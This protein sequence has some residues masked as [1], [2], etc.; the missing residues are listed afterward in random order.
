M[1]KGK[2]EYEWDN[3]E[4]EK[5][6][7]EKSKCENKFGCMLNEWPIT[8]KKRDIFAEVRVVEAIMMFRNFKKLLKVSIWK[9]GEPP[10]TFYYDIKAAKGDDN[11]LWRRL[12]K[13]LCL[14][15]QKQ[16]KEE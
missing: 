15:D 9:S 12:K 4:F 7:K 6:R 1:S 2:L 10:G 16:D 14:I 11:K 13:E 5:L 3:I 8:D